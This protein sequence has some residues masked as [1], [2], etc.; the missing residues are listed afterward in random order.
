[1]K[2]LS[3]R[4]KILLMLGQVTSEIAEALYILDKLMKE[5]REENKEPNRK[6]EES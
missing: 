4:I 1:M 6:K 3:D 2:E 5:L